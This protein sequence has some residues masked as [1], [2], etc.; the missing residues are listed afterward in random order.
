[1]KQKVDLDRQ[2]QETVVRTSEL[3]LRNHREEHC[4]KSQSISSLVH[5]YPLLLH[6]VTEWHLRALNKF[7]AEK[8]KARCWDPDRSMPCFERISFIVPFPLTL[9]EPMTNLLREF[10]AECNIPEQSFPQTSNFNISDRCP[11]ITWNDLEPRCRD[12]NHCFPRKCVFVNYTVDVMSFFRH[13]NETQKFLGSHEK[14]L[15]KVVDRAKS[16]QEIVRGHL[17]L[18]VSQ[19]RP[20]RVIFDPVKETVK[21][22]F[23][24]EAVRNCSLC[25][26]SS[27]RKCGKTL[28]V[29]L[30]SWYNS[31]RRRLKVKRKRQKKC[32][33]ETNKAN[34]GN[35]RSEARTSH[36]HHYVS[37]YT[38]NNLP[39]IPDRC[40]Y[41]KV[42][43][44]KPTDQLWSQAIKAAINSGG[45]Y[46]GQR[47]MFRSL[48]DVMSFFRSDQCPSIHVPTLSNCV[49]IATGKRP[50][51]YVVQVIVNES[52][53]F[54]IERNPR[55]QNVR[56]KFFVQITKASSTECLS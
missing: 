11:P 4:L 32:D 8:F 17:A 18:N 27:K 40:I 10:E 53:P 43:G 42:K 16:Q 13:V 26:K 31:T 6:E 5:V 49:N 39:S 54:V 29:M 37:D 21:I 25:Q 2:L 36:N 55:L 33:K 38:N 47:I 34:L 12:A 50:G 35:W 56:L 7:K 30:H 45:F 23:H 22:T 24:I 41:I 44:L 52:T 19:G 20:F 15:S 46:S 51:L 28:S 48:E 1:M 9:W 3:V 14:I